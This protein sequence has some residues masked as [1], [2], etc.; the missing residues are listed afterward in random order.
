MKIRLVRGS[1]SGQGVGELALLVPVFK[2]VVALVIAGAV[3]T[4]LSGALKFG[5]DAKLIATDR[6]VLSVALFGVALE[7]SA[8]WG[9]NP[10]EAVE[11]MADGKI[12]DEPEPEP[13]PEPLIKVVSR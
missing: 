11:E 8:Y 9:A 2:R 12:G 13:T 3:P 6:A 1:V 5:I 4:R 7:L 10:G